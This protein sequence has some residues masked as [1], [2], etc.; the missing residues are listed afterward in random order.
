MIKYDK[1]KYEALDSKGNTI[2]G[3][4]EAPNQK[5]AI[6]QIRNK[7]LFPT[8]VK[9][10]LTVCSNLKIDKLKKPL[11]NYIADIFFAIGNSIKK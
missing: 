9:G 10:I 4:I 1:F 7:G 11:I 5:D 2:E 3:T 8:K 6:C